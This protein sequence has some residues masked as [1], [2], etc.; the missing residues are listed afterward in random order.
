MKKLLISILAIAAITAC[1]KS[2]VEFEQTGEITFSPVAKNMTKSMMT[3]TAF[4][5]SESFNVWAWYKQVPA[6]TTVADWTAGANEHLYIT[7]GT[8]VNKDDNWGG[9]TPY[10][11]PKVGSLLFAG[12]YPITISNSV[13]YTFN[14]N[15]NKMVFSDIAQSQVAVATEPATYSEDI[16]YFNMTEK[17]HS[18]GSVAVVFKHALSWITVNLSR[19]TANASDAEYPKIHVNSVTF[20]N[21]N[22]K[23]T[24]TVTGTDGIITWATN[25]KA[26]N[27]VVTP[28]AGVTLTTTP[29][30]QTEP[31]FIPQTLTDGTGSTPDMELQ[32]NYTISSSATETFT[33]TYTINL[34]GMSTTDTDADGN[35]IKISAWEPAKHYIYNISIGIEEIL[36]APTVAE[37]TS[38]T[39]NLPVE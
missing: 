39:V 19:P 20:T 7:E 29:Q 9:K 33:E 15:D 23:G 34:A 1:S 18:S 24:G 16:M 26:A 10:Y 25:G 31:L 37:W 36:I 13:D 28:D 6:Q 4:Q 27:T 22:D 14:A 12:Y 38:V 2:E 21:V 30:K 17:S 3:G 5:T 35:E 32:V 11:W 8:F